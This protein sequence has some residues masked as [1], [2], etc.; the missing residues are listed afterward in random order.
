MKGISVRD[1]VPATAAGRTFVLISL[2]NAI[3]TGLFLTG[4]TIFFVRQVG[5]SSGQVGL[6]LAVASAVGFLATVP[7]GGIG[8][9]YG[10]KPTLVGLLLWRG[11]WFVA[12]AF[13]TGMASFVVVACCLAVAEAAT[14]PMTHAVAA[15]TA[16]PADRTRTMAILRTVRNIGF[17]LGALAA[18]P[19]LAADS[20]WAY[21]GLILGTAVAFLVSALLLVRLTLVQ[22]ST[23]E[24]KMGPL[25]AVKGFRDWR[26]ALLGGLGG[27]LDLHQTI[28]TVGL[29]LWALQATDLSPSFVSLLV[30]VNTVLAVLLQVPL[31]RGV[32]QAGRA[33][34]ALRLSGVALAGCAI[35][36]AVAAAPMP[37]L[38]AGGVLVVGCVLLTLGELW[39]AVGAW[40]L[41]YTLAPAERRAVYLSVFSLGNTGQRI[42]GPVLLTSAV[43]AAGSAGWVV[44]AVGFVLVAALVTPVARMQLS[45][46]GKAEE[47]PAPDSS[48]EVSS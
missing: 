24:R 40:E 14:M 34:R 33:Q 47:S 6:G 42:V 7:I 41:S 48:E 43:I 45:T 21:R 23:V 16:A 4:S 25:Q 38:V 29:P 44:L 13:T 19:L 37:T 22:P 20:P 1:Y 9:R 3:G 46:R 12:L 26:Y 39:H 27:A 36:L 11:V 31:S 2:L 5:L 18:A 10:A 8:D 15:A 32:E 35:A 30:L 17:S 28:L